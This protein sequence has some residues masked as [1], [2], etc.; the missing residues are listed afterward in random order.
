MPVENIPEPHLIFHSQSISITYKEMTN[1]DVGVSP[2]SPYSFHN[3]VI[4][5]SRNSTRTFHAYISF[6]QMSQAL[7]LNI[8]DMSNPSFLFNVCIRIHYFHT[9]SGE[10]EREWQGKTE[11]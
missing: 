1:E 11:A 9:Y 4:W 3:T 10:R 5:Q 6:S 8:F 2:S 7:K